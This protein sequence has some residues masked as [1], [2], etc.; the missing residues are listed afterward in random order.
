MALQK[1]PP[2]VSVCLWLLSSQNP[3]LGDATRNLKGTGRVE[4]LAL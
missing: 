1:L 3:N 4:Q 2:Q